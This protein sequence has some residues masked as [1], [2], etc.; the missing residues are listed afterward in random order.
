[1]APLLLSRQGAKDS[2][3]LTSNQEALVSCPG[4][5]GSVCCAFELSGSKRS[6]DVIATGMWLPP[7][8]PPYPDETPEPAHLD[9]EQ[10]CKLE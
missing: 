8:R 10:L 1:M 9:V 4:D 2:I 6:I 5:E 3:S 7:E